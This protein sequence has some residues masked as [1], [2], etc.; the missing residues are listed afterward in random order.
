MNAGAPGAAPTFLV[1][2]DGSEQALA[3]A[4]FTAAL[5]EA[6]G[7]SVMLAAVHPEDV[8]SDAARL[9]V[10]GVDLPAARRAVHA[11]SSPGRGLHELAER[12]QA[13]MVAVGV[14]DRYGVGRLKPGGVAELLL[15]GS[16]RPVLVVGSDLPE[17]GVRTVGVA[18]A[19]DVEGDEALAAGA[20]LAHDLGAD[21]RL[22]SV[23]E[24][25]PA[26]LSAPD[27]LREGRRME[28]E[29]HLA[30]LAHQHAGRVRPASR[31]VVAHPGPALVREGDDVDL[32]VLGSRG[33]GPPGSVLLGSVSR[34]VVAHARCPV[35]VV[36]RAAAKSQ[37]AVA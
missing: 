29:Q 5:A 11:A 10:D 8:P 24:P 13:A 12:E 21:L 18:H 3:A 15:H 17:D 20:A 7:G 32:L 36:P 22:V 27:E 34:R 30:G 23:V 4:R 31:A 6:R 1:G 14:P 9:G 2:I 25:G 33:Y 37:V 19:G 28:R 26:G 35:L 16:G